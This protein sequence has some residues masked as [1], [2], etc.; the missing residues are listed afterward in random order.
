MKENKRLKF[1]G[2]I[3]LI[4]ILLLSLLSI[5]I[6]SLVFVQVKQVVNNNIYK[7]LDSNINLAYEL[8]EATYP[9]EWNVQGDK[10]YKGKKLINGDTRLVDKVKRLTNAPATIALGD[11]RISTNVVIDGKRAEGTKISQEVADR[12][13][14]KNEIF[15]GEANVLNTIYESKYVPIK[16]SSGKSIG[17]WFM[18][19]E[20]SNVNKEINKLMFIIIIITFM[21][22][23]VAIVISIL[24]TNSIDKNIK[25]ILRFLKQISSG[26]LT[27][28]CHIQSSDETKDISNGLNDMTKNI[29]SII[30]NIKETSRNVYESSDYLTSISEE[31]ASSSQN[32]TVA[33]QDVA[34]GT[35]EQAQNL[36]DITSILNEFGGQIENIVD[37]I[38][39]IE[40]NSRGINT[41]ASESNSKMKFL[42]DSV[43]KVNA[44]FHD[45]LARISGLG[46]NIN[47]IN[48]ITTMIN[49][50]ADQT[51]L[52]ALNAAIEAAR[53]GE[54]GRGFAVVAEEIRTLAIQS[55]ESSQN[56]NQVISTIVEDTKE[57][58]EM[59]N[60]MNNE[61]NNQVG[62]IHTTIHS[63]KGITKGVS[64]VI[65]K[66]ENVNTAA[67]KIEKEKDTI[68]EKIK[69]SSSIAQ[70]VSSSAEE[71]AASSEGMSTS[72]EQVAHKIYNLNRVAKEMESKV[73]QFKLQKIEG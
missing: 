21:I 62:V 24:L 49:S 47:K 17:I 36:I 67:E 7:Q 18:G 31:M 66:I 52:L 46:E 16:D 65:P 61:V 50:V 26:D 20:K 32:V 44:S 57:M 11:T 71:I 53:A 38:K 70:G 9:G 58:I 14:I 1:K 13:L 48:E 33:I 4:V 72:I 28:I 51:N 22:V 60:V 6:L 56:I 15:S 2:K 30:C 35:S 73:N 34:M 43:N 27:D 29:Q 68:V 42:V 8:L 41:M 63:F 64:E 3:L 40:Y 59:T 69:N 23:G 10:L 5:T 25:K 39:E 45:F 12:V 37:S 19:V 54:S 55:K